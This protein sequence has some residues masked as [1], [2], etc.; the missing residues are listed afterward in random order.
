MRRVIA[1]FLSILMLSAILCACGSQQKTADKNEK[2]TTATATADEK[3]VEKTEIF[4]FAAASMTETLESL[5]KTYQA[6]HPEIEITYRRG[7][8][9][10][11]LYLRGAKTDERAGR[12]R[13]YQQGH[14][15]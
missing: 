6:S 10:R 9:L 3:S 5:K 4:V 12:R 2:E 8:C 14:P 1:L 15:S 7:R 11:S 13:L